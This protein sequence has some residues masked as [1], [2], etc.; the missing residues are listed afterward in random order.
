MGR[1][2]GGD[3]GGD[4]GNRM[5]DVHALVRWESASP[6]SAAE[7]KSAPAE[8]AESYVISVTGLRVREHEQDQQNFLQ[9]DESDREKETERR[10]LRAASLEIKGKDPIAPSHIRKEDGDGGPIWI[11]RFPRSGNPI[12]AEDKEVLFLLHLG[13][14]NL[15]AKF[16]LKDMTYKDQ[17]AL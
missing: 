12:S 2:R 8:V 17:L 4:S 15:K 3:M 6:V 13:R 10:M 11:Y 5:P 1:S 16:P 9:S 7:K 14:I